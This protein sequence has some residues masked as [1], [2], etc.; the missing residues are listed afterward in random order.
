MD[1][2][3]HLQRFYRQGLTSGSEIEDGTA[4]RVVSSEGYRHVVRP[5]RKLEDA[6]ADKGE[7]GRQG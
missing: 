2:L 7:E 3:D 4:V 5:L 1:R 6:S